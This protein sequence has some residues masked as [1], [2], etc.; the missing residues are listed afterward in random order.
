MSYDF[1]GRA[2]A[3]TRMIHIMYGQNNDQNLI[4]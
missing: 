4:K 3:T 2:T 1:H